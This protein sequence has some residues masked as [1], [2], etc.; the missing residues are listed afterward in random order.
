MNPMKPAA[1]GSASTLLREHLGDAL[2]RHRLRQGRT[3][4]EVSAIARVSLAYLSEIERGRK[5]ASSELLAAVC[6]ALEVP[7]S[8]LLIEVSDQI[9]LAELAART[10]MPTRRI[11][12][13]AIAVHRGQG[14]GS[15]PIASLATSAA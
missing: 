12:S 14:P 7:L 9:A 1:G 3:L 8:S 13:R 6:E 2:R 11:D 15:T 10:P 5:E 4:R